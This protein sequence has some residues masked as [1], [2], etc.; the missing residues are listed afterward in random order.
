MI[1]AFYFKVC[2]STYPASSLKV[3]K[4][5]SDSLE[6]RKIMIY[7]VL[8]FILNNLNTC[9]CINK[10]GMVSV[11]TRKLRQIRKICIKKTTK[12]TTICCTSESV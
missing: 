7:I 9:I 12:K 5:I 3:Y 6:H 1:S 11:Y 10:R 8:S 2:S 4:A